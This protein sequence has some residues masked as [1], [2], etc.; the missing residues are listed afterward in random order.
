[1]GN[2]PENIARAV[3]KIRGLPL[4]NPN[5]DLDI[6]AHAVEGTV[7]PAPDGFKPTPAQGI[8]RDADFW[9]AAYL[10]EEDWLMVQAG[11]AR[12]FGKTLPEWLVGN[13][14]YL[15]TVPTHSV[16]GEYIAPQFRPILVK[17]AEI[18]VERLVR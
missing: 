3:E 8:L 11:L 18:W 7:F 4:W 2:D 14:N 16:W 6:A 13:I 1:M 10:S 12:E 5:V 15:R 9:H 17:Q